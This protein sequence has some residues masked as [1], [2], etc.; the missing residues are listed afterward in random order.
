MTDSRTTDTSPLNPP[1]RSDDLAAELAGEEPVD[2]QDGILD[3]DQ[4]EIDDGGITD[5]EL[6]AGEAGLI[7]GDGPVD[8]PESLELLTDL[9]LRSDETSDPDVASEEGLAWVPP[10]DP[11]VV[12]SGDQG[13][14][15]AA[16]F[17]STSRDEP[18]DEDHHAELLGNEDEMTE[19][20]REALRADAATS[21]LAD[22]VEIETSGST[23]ILRGVV[24]DLD[25]DDNLVAVASTVTGVAE[26]VDEL[27]IASL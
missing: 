14:A 16:G 10:T 8:R 23:V 15:I 25:D 21:E 9:D 11:P 19:R 5:S 2:R 13:V 3:P 20:V 24:D 7:G 22:S 12:P 6:D 1:D 18:Y 27:D 26:V 17:G 4:V